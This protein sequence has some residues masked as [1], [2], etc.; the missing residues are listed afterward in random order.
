MISFSKLMYFMCKRVSLT[1]WKLLKLL[2]K[3]S[4]MIYITQCAVNR[5]RCCEG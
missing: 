5:K 2:K 4:D 3:G 1:S